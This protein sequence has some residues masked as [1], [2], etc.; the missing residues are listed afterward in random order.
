MGPNV[1]LTVE[2]QRR[3]PSAPVT[4]AELPVLVVACGG[5]PD[6][7]GAARRPHPML[8]PAILGIP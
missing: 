4:S 2:Q 8:G 6:E 3:E 1:E 7:E 5:L